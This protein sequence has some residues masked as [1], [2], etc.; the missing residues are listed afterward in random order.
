M[1]MQAIARKY[2]DTGVTKEYDL[3]DKTM[4]CWELVD[5]DTLPEDVNWCE[6]GIQNIKF[7]IKFEQAVNMASTSDTR[8]EFMLLAIKSART[9]TSL[10]HSRQQPFTSQS[11]VYLLLL[12]CL[13]GM[14]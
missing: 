14:A 4:G 7:K 9:S 3:L 5:I 11:G 12:P 6:M 10:R 1:C 13:T 2:D 8:Q